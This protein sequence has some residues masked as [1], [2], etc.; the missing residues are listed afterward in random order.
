MYSY[1]DPFNFTFINLGRF[2]LTI[3]S[4]T[5]SACI[6]NAWLIF[7][8]LSFLFSILGSACFAFARKTSHA[9]V[10]A[11]QI[12]A[13]AE[14]GRLTVPRRL[15]MPSCRSE[16]ERERERESLSSQYV[17]ACM[18]F[19]PFPWGIVIFSNR[20]TLCVVISQLEACFI[21]SHDMLCVTGWYKK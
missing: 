15:L 11:Q 5:S 13:A 16:V 17:S 1:L 14:R 6:L 3:L 8:L 21:L 4:S 10:F 7:L 18:A 12:E 19:P 9:D 20:M 2:L